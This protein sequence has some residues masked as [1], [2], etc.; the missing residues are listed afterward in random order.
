MY[1]DAMFGALYNAWRTIQE[2]ADGTTV[3][4]TGTRRHHDIVWD[5]LGWDELLQKRTLQNQLLLALSHRWI[6]FIIAST[7]VHK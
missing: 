7:S 4:R 6:T 1:L 5:K 2:P 3:S